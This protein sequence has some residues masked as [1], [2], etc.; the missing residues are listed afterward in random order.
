[1]LSFYS[2][3]GKR[4]E[5]LLNSLKNRDEHVKDVLKD[6]C[7][8]ILKKKNSRMRRRGEFNNDI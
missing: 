8:E 2:E 7:M 6:I 3:Y 1:M 4:L 5:I